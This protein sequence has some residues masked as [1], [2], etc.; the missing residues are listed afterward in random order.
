VGG[1]W[2]EDSRNLIEITQFKD[3]HDVECAAE[4]LA[5]KGIDPGAYCTVFNLYIRPWLFGEVSW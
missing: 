1:S 2:V 5:V 3:K 4:Y